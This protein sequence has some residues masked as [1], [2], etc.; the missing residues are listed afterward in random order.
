MCFKQYKLVIYSSGDDKSNMAN[1]G[2][3][4]RSGRTVFFSEGAR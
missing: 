4:S 1:S 3:K 2:L